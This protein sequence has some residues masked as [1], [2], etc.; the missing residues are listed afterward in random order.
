[1]LENVVFRQNR[2]CPD[3]SSLFEI[4]LG[5]RTD[6]CQFWR[7]Q[8]PSFL[9]NVIEWFRE[10]CSKKAA[11]VY[12]YY[13]IFLKAQETWL[14]W[15]FQIA[16]PPV[17]TKNDSSRE[18]LQTKMPLTYCKIF[19]GSIRLPL[20][21]V[22]LALQLL[23]L[24]PIRFS[25]AAILLSNENPVTAAY[26]TFLAKTIRYQFRCSSTNKMLLSCYTSL[27]A[28]EWNM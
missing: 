15:E 13:Q 12:G 2:H 20:V 1:M 6:P 3:V 19:A 16:R 5:L 10:S 9:R 27:S 18:R 7:N 25:D 22:L 8:F 11:E 4:F 26:F 17:G 24:A 21:A 28:R 14:L 23:S